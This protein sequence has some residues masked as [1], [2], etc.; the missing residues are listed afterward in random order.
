MEHFHHTHPGT[1]LSHWTA[2]RLNPGQRLARASVGL[3]LAALLWLFGGAACAQTTQ[4]PW[5]G[6]DMSTASS[7]WQVLM[8]SAQPIGSGE[9]YFW[10][11]LIY[12]ATLWSPT[13]TYD[14][15]NP[16]ALSLTYARDISR[17]DIVDASIKQMEGLGLPVQNH[18]E[19][20]NAL[21]TVFRSVKKGDTFTG[22]YQPGQGATFFYNTQPTGEV[23]ESLA[24]AFFAIW[25]DPR[26]SQPELRSALLGEA[27]DN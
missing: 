15:D 21:E 19:W 27:G 22:V 1:I 13:G 7:A 11:W 2:D 5:Q 26:T 18:P 23:G 10:G 16:F 17:Q 9:L 8:P 6:T 24:Q 25:L 20:G 3:M 14:A 12:D 4:Q